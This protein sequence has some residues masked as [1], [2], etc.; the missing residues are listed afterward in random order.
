MPKS[1]NRRK[2][3]KLKAP[4]KRASLGKVEETNGDRP[5]MYQGT[6]EA[7]CGSMV[8]YITPMELPSL[9]E[10]RRQAISDHI[11]EG[12]CPAPDVCVDALATGEF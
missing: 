9:E 10:Y 12:E 8:A 11:A 2:K 1:D 7:P 4:K 3:A 6:F 5:R